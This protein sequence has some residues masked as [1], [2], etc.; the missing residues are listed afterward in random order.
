MLPKD[1]PPCST[2]QRYF[3]DWRAMRLWS[4]INHSLVMTTREL[5]GSKRHR[6]QAQLTARALKPLKAGVSEA[7][8]LA[9]RSRAASVISLSISLA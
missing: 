7:L 8:M 9:R 1:F 6:R 5:E 3:Y 2:V 4:R